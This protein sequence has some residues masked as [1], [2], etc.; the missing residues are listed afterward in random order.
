[1]Y[2]VF[3][4]YRRDTGK[5]LASSFVQL[6]EHHGFVPYFD[7][8]DHTT[9]E[10]RNNIKEAISYSNC[11]FSSSNFLFFLL[12]DEIRASL[13]LSFISRFTCLGVDTCD[14]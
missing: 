5:D 14:C 2:D 7:I 12:S 3:I 6:I 8:S 1:M 9:G 13:L 4:S 10:F 11:M